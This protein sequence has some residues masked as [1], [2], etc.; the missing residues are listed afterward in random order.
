MINLKNIRKR[1]KKTN[2]YKKYQKLAILGILAVIIIIIIFT[3]RNREGI[4]DKAKNAIIGEDGRVTTISRASLD[5]VFEISELSTADYTYN[6]IATAYENDNKTVKYYVAYEGRVKAGID[7]GKI[8]I[9]ISEE[10]K[11]ITITLPEIEFQEKTVDPATLQYIF[12][13][14]KNETETVYQEAFVLCER[15]LD[16]KT[17][18]EE[19]L[20]TLARENAVAVVE[21]LVTPWV[22][23]IN[24]EYIVEIS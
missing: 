2:K 18:Q 12:K 4:I 19:E 15:D 11:L 10:E 7:F 24:N 9:E 20:L 14:K 13:D 16:K 1:R 6:A 22:Q 23:Q 8:E 3:G 17:E 21:A 5:K